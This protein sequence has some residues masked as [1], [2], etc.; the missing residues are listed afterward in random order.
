MNRTLI[1]KPRAQIDVADIFDHLLGAD[2]RV[3]MR[4]FDAYDAALPIIEKF[5]EAGGRLLL[6]GHEDLD[7][8][9][10]RPKGFDMYLIFHRVMDVTIEV[11]RVLHAS[12]DL[13]AAL[14]GR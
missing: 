10:V 7:F 3:A 14:E 8:R 12:R 4:F 6:E 9:Y 2:P 5:P 13:A 11:A 1:V